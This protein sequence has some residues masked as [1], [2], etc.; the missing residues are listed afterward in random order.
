LLGLGH[1]FGQEGQVIELHA[2]KLELEA[3]FVGVNGEGTD[4]ALRI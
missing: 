1:E 4:G 2:S 3:L